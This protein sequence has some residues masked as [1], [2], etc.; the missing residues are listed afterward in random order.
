MKKIILILYIITIA[1]F[2][3][4][5]DGIIKKLKKDAAKT[6]VKDTSD[7]IIKKWKR[8]ACLASM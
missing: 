7:T 1:E 5:Q 8:G 3:L 2:T 6:I 4:A